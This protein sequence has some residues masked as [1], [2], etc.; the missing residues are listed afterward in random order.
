M[1][2]KKTFEYTFNSS[3]EHQSTQSFNY[4][5]CIAGMVNNISSSESKM[6]RF[7]MQLALDN[8]S[9]MNSIYT[10]IL[11]HSCCLCVNEILHLIT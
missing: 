4:G 10:E 7:E 8:A 3:T 1:K 2:V 5:I 11:H 9:C 6:T